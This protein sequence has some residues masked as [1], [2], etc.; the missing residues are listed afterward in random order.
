MAAPGLLTGVG[1]SAM[2]SSATCENWTGTQPPDP[3]TE[4]NKLF[5]VAILAGCDAWAVGDDRG[6][7]NV[8]RTLIEHWNGSSWKVVA[9]PDPPHPAS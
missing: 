9:S 4:T 6:S 8:T 2:A 5:G 3:G 1:A 7:D